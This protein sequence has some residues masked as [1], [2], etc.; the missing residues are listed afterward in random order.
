MAS[1]T[2]SSLSMIQNTFGGA[3]DVP[4]VTDYD[5]AVRL[6]DEA[7]GA[8]TSAQKTQPIFTP[9]PDTD[10]LKSRE[11]ATTMSPDEFLNL[12]TD[13]PENRV[14][15]DSEKFIREQIAKGE[16]LDTPFLNF[17]LNDKGVATV[18]GHEGRHR[19]RI[20]KEMGITEMP[21]RLKSQGKNEIRWS[22]QTDPKNRDRLD[23]PW[24]TTLAPQEGSSGSPIAFP[25]SD[26]LKNNA[27]PI[28]KAGGG[29]VERVYNDNR[30]YK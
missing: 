8:V 28:K 7:L 1:P 16:P 5:D 9:S 6:Q 3:K 14:D 22:E 26:P 21:V 12:A 27:M 30:T 13:L 29:L 2:L 19:A 18:T 11:T 10:A 15:L 23:V 25:I 17:E 24:P 20:L 4:V